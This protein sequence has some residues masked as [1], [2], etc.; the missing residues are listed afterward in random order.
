MPHLTLHNAVLLFAVAV[1][2]GAINSVAGGGSFVCFPVLLF[3]GVP[4]IQANATN[5]MALWPGTVA[6]VGAYRRE[7]VG[8]NSKLLIPLV[9][10][11]LIGGVIG[12]LTLLHTPQATFLRLIPYLIGIATVLFAISGRVTRFLRSRSS[13]LQSRSRFAVIGAALLQLIIAVYIGF[14]GAGAGIL[15]LAMLALLGIES[16]HTMNAYKTVLA[17]VGNGIAIAM[18]VIAGAILWPQAIVMLLGASVGGYGGAYYAQ[19]MNPQ[20]VRWMVIAIGVLLTVYFFWKQG[21]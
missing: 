16:I 7:L 21:L 19:K 10:T 14:F 2:G 5:T 11:G 1:I 20:H 4:P 9:C 12:A 13:H 15:M 3:T 6:S 18:F 17:T 8:E